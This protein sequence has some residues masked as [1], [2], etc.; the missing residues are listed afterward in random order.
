MAARGDAIHKSLQNLI[1]QRCHGKGR[2]TKPLR[3]AVESGMA[4]LNNSDGCGGLHPETI[5]PQQVP[6]TLQPSE[7]TIARRNI[8]MSRP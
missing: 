3:E 1:P 7:S 5:P 2:L 4:G 8:S 6:N